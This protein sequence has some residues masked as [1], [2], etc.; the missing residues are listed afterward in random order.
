MTSRLVASAIVSTGATCHT[1]ASATSVRRR[2]K[3]IEF[4]RIEIRLWNPEERREGG[5]IV[6]QADD[7]G[8]IRRNVLHVER[9][10]DGC[11][12]QALHNLSDEQAEYQVRDRLSF[13][14]FLRLGIED[15]IPDATTLWLF[16]EKLAK[17]GA[18]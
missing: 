12:G 5:C 4:N 9:D 2:A 10:L 18:D 8:V 15:G 11:A 3:P 6:P 17:A 14:R 1:T 13:T 7:R 16:R